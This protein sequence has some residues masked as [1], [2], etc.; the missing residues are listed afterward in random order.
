MGIYRYTET[1]PTAGRLCG[2]MAF[3]HA[4]RIDHYAAD[5]RDLNSIIEITRVL[6]AAHKRLKVRHPDHP[7][8]R[9]IAC[10][11]CT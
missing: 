1:L 3:G 7:A 9:G 6:A 2:K 8:W 10:Q 5:T 4:D 11:S